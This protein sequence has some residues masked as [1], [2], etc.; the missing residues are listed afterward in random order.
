[1]SRHL[2][3]MSDEPWAA[4]EPHLPRGRP[5]KP[6]VDDRRVIS[7]ILHV[8]RTGCRWRDVPEAYGP[9]H[10]LQP[11]QPLVRAGRLTQAVRGD[12]RRRGDPRRVLDR[13]HPC[14]GTPLG[15]GLKKGSGRKPSAGREAGEPRRSTAWPMF[16]ADRSPSRCPGQRRRHLHGHSFSGGQRTVA[17]ADRGQGLRCRPPA[18]LARGAPHQGGDPLNGNPETVQINRATSLAV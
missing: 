2:F 7:G 17:P 8:L 1:M 18:P 14:E 9:H 4:I 13:Q 16:R 15:G 3:W 11:P 12:G 10:D 6:R 5:G